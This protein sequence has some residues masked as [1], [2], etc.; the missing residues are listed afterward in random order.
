V[1]LP[2]FQQRNLPQIEGRVRQVAADATDDPQTGKRF[3]AVRIEIDAGQLA[4]LEPPLELTPGMP[5]EV[6]ITTGEHTAL[7]Y[8]LSP[9]YASLR[10]AFRET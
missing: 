3:F 4:A 6:Y 1:V 10:R 7:D 5:A 8:L 9:F 2:A